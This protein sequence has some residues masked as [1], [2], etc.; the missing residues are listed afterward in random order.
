MYGPMV[1]PHTCFLLSFIH[2]KVETKRHIHTENNNTGTSNFIT[3][4][5]KAL[6]YNG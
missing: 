4:S 1:L 3:I 5:S 6:Y 2:N